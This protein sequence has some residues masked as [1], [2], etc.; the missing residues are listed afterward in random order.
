LS[1]LLCGRASSRYLHRASL[2][3][4]FFS[5]DRRMD[6]FFLFPLG[7]F[8]PPPPLSNVIVS[9][10]FSLL[11]FVFASL[12][13]LIT[14]FQYCHFMLILIFVTRRHD[15][16]HDVHAPL[17]HLFRTFNVHTSILTTNTF[18]PFIPSPRRPLYC[19]FWLFLSSSF[20]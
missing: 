12:Y 9:S 4:P 20:L 11:L 15:A 14:L 8:S 17:P 5:S 10:S 13:P 3:P 7:P 18:L 2:H 16:S 6:C 1:S 19:V